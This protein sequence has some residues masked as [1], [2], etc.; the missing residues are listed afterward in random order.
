MRDAIAAEW[1][2]L[3]SVRSTRWVLA[4]VAAFVVL[5]LALAFQEAQIFDGLAPGRREK[6]ALRPLQEMSPWVTGLCMAVTGVLTATSEYRSG[7][8]R[9]SLVAVPRRSR[10][11]AAK[12]VVV[13]AVSL[14]AGEAATLG[15]FLG[16]R[17]VIGDRPFVD[18]RAPLPHDLPGFGV[19][20]VSVP[21]FALLGLALGLLLRSAAAA[22][23][24]VVL[25]WHVLPLLVF[26]LPAPWNE[27]LGS[28]ML[29]GLGPRAAGHSVE[30]SI[31]GGALPPWGAAA[32][33][34]AY[35]L[36]PLVVAVSVFARRDA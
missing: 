8:I 16:S 11:P 21:V 3:C 13:T 36:L 30:N 10:L 7:T 5:L 9:S 20:A 19:E 6:L 15:T 27:R 23:T 25:L 29:G 4:I 12:A 1:W 17:L 2:K 24:A 32:L 34:L 28:V 18:Q 33:M 31:Y 35:A 22:I 14:A 26:H